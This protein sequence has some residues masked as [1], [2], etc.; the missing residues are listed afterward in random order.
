MNRGLLM[1]LLLACCMIA[2]LVWTLEQESRDVSVVTVAGDIGMRQRKEIYGYL[3]EM[4]NVGDIR[5]VKARLDRV[6]WVHRV[7]VERDWPDGLVINVH[8]EEAIA[9]WNDDA[10][11]NEEG[12]VFISSYEEG[13]RLP[14]LYG[15]EGREETVMSQYQQLSQAL[16]RTG[17]VIDTLRFD[18]RGSWEF[19]T[20]TGVKVLLG[21]EGI[22]ERM[23]RYFLVF[24]SAALLEELSKI[25]TVDTRYSNGVAV[26]WRTPMEGY[27]VAK[28]YKSQ[29]D[30]SL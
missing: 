19:T 8:E 14:Q 9:Y 24:Q 17:Q 3:S 25:K 26:D 23:Q 5:D 18:E 15:P 22:M 21:K 7:E 1:A 20:R 12:H 6:D 30:M 2:S 10:W 29:R 11:I 27:E 4:V 13:G 28:A 16:L